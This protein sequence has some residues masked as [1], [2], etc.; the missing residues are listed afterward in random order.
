MRGP[1][2]GRARLQLAGE[3]CCGVLCQGGLHSKGCR[4]AKM[5]RLHLLRLWSGRRLLQTLY[6]TGLNR[7]LISSC[8]AALPPGDLHFM[9]RHSFRQYGAG[10]SPSLAPSELP[11]PAGAGRARVMAGCREHRLV[12]VL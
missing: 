5:S 7:L 11:T 3:A 10:Q 12:R 9:M 4:A 8:S 6:F 2:R 1:L